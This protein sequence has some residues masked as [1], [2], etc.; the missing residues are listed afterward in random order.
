MRSPILLILLLSA[1]T[2]ALSLHETHDSP[3]DHGSLHYYHRFARDHTSP[4][5][6]HIPLQEHYSNERNLRKQTYKI[7]DQIK[8]V[9]RQAGFH[10]RAVKHQLLALKNQAN[11]LENN[12]A[13]DS[14]VANQKEQ[15]IK[16]D[17]NHSEKFREIYSQRG[18]EN[19][20]KL[21]SALPDQVPSMTELVKF[22][23]ERTAHWTQKETRQQ[24]DLESTV[25]GDIKEGAKNADM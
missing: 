12:A 18:K 14:K 1:S 16:E 6:T 13:A 19:S 5:N 23:H 10:E 22:D 11:K 25:S 21:A 24:A 9:E 4:L 8:T 3:S 17:I 20:E 2:L 15:S 7:T